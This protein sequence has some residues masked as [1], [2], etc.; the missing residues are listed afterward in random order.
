ML[1]FSPV[2]H[3]VIKNILSGNRST[4]AEDMAEGN[5]MHFSHDFL[6]YKLWRSLSKPALTMQHLQE[7][8]LLPLLLWT[9]KIAWLLYFGQ[10]CSYSYFMY[11]VM[12]QMW[13]L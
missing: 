3:K 7:L 6:V 11:L 5:K 9:G 8:V 13:V 4:F 10:N 2:E 12:R 1:A